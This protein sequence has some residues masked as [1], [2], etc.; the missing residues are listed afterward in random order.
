[1]R[2]LVSR[3]SMNKALGCCNKS[4]KAYKA[5]LFLMSLLYNFSKIERVENERR[6]YL[7]KKEENLFQM[8]KKVEVRT[9][10][11]F[12]LCHLT[13]F[14]MLVVILFLFLKYRL[15]TPQGRPLV[16]TARLILNHLMASLFVSKLFTLKFLPLLH[17]VILYLNI[18]RNQFLMKI[19]LKSKFIAKILKMI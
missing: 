18:L 11:F 2:K 8:R 16:R 3:L 4:T 19:F 5:L 15:K 6:G 17:F 14:Q 12:I 13:L 1:M 7:I 10:T 9:S